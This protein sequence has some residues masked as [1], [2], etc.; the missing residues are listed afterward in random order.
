M[1][2][3]KPWFCQGGKGAVIW[4][5]TGSASGRGNKALHLSNLFTWSKQSVFHTKKINKLSSTSTCDLLP[6]HARGIT[7]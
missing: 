2:T 1:E 3:M 5:C 4:L 7:A 6:A